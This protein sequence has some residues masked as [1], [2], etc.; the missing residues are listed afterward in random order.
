MENLE[1]DFGASNE[2]QIYKTASLYDLIML[3][4]KPSQSETVQDLDDVPE[5]HQ[6]FIQRA[7]TQQVP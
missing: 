5:L 6:S 4:V 3:S 2:E 7:L 1:I